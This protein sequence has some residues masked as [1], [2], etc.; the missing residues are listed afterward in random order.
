MQRSLQQKRAINRTLDEVLQW[1]HQKHTK[2]TICTDSRSVIQAVADTKQNAHK[3]EYIVDIRH[4][5]AMY[6]RNNND[7]RV[8]LAWVLAHVGV[9]HNEQVDARQDSYQTTTR[10]RIV[11]TSVRCVYRH[12]GQ[13]NGD[14]GGK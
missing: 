6:Q 10:K 7:N 4:K 8:G 13:T 3:H 1:Q 14:H 5:I 12:P 9:G 11:Y 2:V